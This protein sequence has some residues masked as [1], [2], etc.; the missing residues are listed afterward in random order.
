[1]SSIKSSTAKLLRRYLNG[2]ITAPEE[3]E[4]EQRAQNDPALA[5]AMLGIQAVPEADHTARVARMTAHARRAAKPNTLRKAGQSRTYW[6]T[7]AA[8]LLIFVSSALIFQPNWLERGPGDLAMKTEATAPQPENLERRSDNTLDEPVVKPGAKDEAVTEPA[9]SSSAPLPRSRPEKPKPATRSQPVKVA[10]P[11]Q[12]SLPAPKMEA[13]A[14]I[15]L[16]EDAGFAEEEADAAVRSEPV[17]P[18]APAAR[19]KRAPLPTP[20]SKKK[21]N[22]IDDLFRADEEG[23][24]PLVPGNYLEGLIT[25]ENGTPIFDALIRQPGLPLGERTDTNGLFRLSYDA[26]TSQLIVSH[27]DYL[28]E[29]IELTEDRTEDL[30]ISL[31]EK[32]NKTS[33]DVL[34]FTQNTARSEIIFDKRPGYAAPRDGYAALR[35]RIEAN[36]PEDVPAG[37]VRLNFLVN[38]DGTL[39]DFKFKGRPTRAT[40]DYVGE[41]LIKSSIWEIRY[42]D[43]EEPVRVHFKV[44]FE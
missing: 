9:P 3:A 35:R 28:V 20:A 6:A 36:R 12:A 5:D 37:K 26:T 42:G 41:Y 13:S 1:M 32:E 17:P 38:Q 22:P 30:Q 43:G 44:V 23:N 7:A 11:A 27:P 8:V 21:S 39:T 24:I 34:G 18:P 4:L 25:D 40:M 10:A 15:S 19:V 14:T 16:E 2:A 31:E 33:D 29:R